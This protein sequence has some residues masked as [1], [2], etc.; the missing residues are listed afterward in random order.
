MK[1]VIRPFAVLPEVLCGKD[2]FKSYDDW[3]AFIKEALERMERGAVLADYGIHQAVSTTGG[4]I[5]ANTVIKHFAKMNFLYRWPTQAPIG[6]GHRT[7]FESL[8]SCGPNENLAGIISVHQNHTSNPPPSTHPLNLAP[9]NIN[10][11]VLSLERSWWAELLQQ[12]IIFEKTPQN[13]RKLLIPLAKQGGHLEV[14][15]P[16][17]NPM[18]ANY[19]HWR[20]LIKQILKNT[21]ATIRIHTSEKA[22]ETS[23]RSSMEF[24][25]AMR[26]LSELICKGSYRLEINLRKHREIPE[27]FHDR[28]IFTRNSISVQFSWG[29]D[30]GNDHKQTVVVLS[31]DTAKEKQKIFNSALTSSLIDSIRL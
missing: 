22:L 14:W 25:S 30:C 28:F 2:G 1:G 24:S 13:Y 29:I 19:V 18:R 3:V 27:G 5:Q 17:F 11:G 26:P 23:Q 9:L 12:E 10:D 8:V 21:K 15:D 20:D 4:Y 6:S 31:P 7:I 16:Y